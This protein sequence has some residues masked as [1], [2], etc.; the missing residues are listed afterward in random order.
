MGNDAPAVGDPA[1][2][3]T[4]PRMEGGDFRLE[5]QSGRPVLVSFLR[6]AG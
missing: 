6:H 5:D 3:L 2:P 4:L 1:P